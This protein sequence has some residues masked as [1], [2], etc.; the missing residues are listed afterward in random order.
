MRTRFEPLTYVLAAVAGW[1][2]VCVV[3][4]MTGFGGH[5]ELLPDNP[6][7]APR[8]PAIATASPHSTM[9]P[10]EV[11][12]EASNHPLFYPNRKPVAVHVPGQ[13]TTP[14]QALD[15]VL[16]SV[17][18]TPTL[19]M[20]I[21]QEPKTR[22]SMRVHEGQ[23]IGGAYGSWKLTGL[24]PRSATF[25]GG[26]QGETTLDLRVFDGKG[27]EEPTRTGLTPQVV[28]SGVLGP[29]R[30]AANTD[31]NAANANMPPPPPPPDAANDTAATDAANVAANNAAVLAAQQAEQ[32]RQRIQQRR[33]QAQTERA[34]A[35][36][37]DR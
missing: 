6:A 25:D 16:T 8:L 13:D 12:A 2:V 24:S 21:V 7:L 19:Q 10:L 37:K 14:A 22:Q 5:Y 3:V 18:M 33:Q 20:A 27:G 23:P 36:N 17:I 28:A 26:S 30:G 29:A 1:A 9:G 15:V 4:S 34:A 11:Y 35:T 32:I 31:P